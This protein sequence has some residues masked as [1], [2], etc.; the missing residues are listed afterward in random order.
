MSVTVPLAYPAAIPVGHRV[1]L[2]WMLQR[3]GLRGNKLSAK[4]FE[5]FLRDLD[6][7]VAYGCEWHVGSFD[8]FRSDRVH[9]YASEPL[10]ELEVERTLRGRVAAC[11][12]VTVAVA[13]PYQHTILV[14][15]EEV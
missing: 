13:D 11:T 1:E 3:G 8:A 5:P 4:P 14:L 7:G 6:S 15:D 12:V 9:P 2:T 10:P